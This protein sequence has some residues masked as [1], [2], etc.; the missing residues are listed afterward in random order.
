M[1]G[2]STTIPG[3]WEPMRKVGAMARELLKVAASQTW[4]T[5]VE[6]LKVSEGRV[7]HPNGQSLPFGDLVSAASLVEAPKEVAL[8]PLQE[9][10]LI[11]EPVHRVDTPAKTDGTAV[12]G[13]DV[14][15][16]GLKVATIA[17]SP[18]FGGQLEQYDASAALAIK[19]V[20]QVIPLD[21]AIAVIADTYWQAK[22]G[23][24]ALQVTFSGGDTELDNDKVYTTLQNTLDDKPLPDLRNASQQLDYE[25]FVPYLAH[26]TM[27]PMNC[28][29]KLSED[30][31]DIWVPSQSQTLTGRI[32]KEL[33]GLDESN[34]HVHLTF[35]GG[36]FGRRGEAD[37]VAQ[38]I[39]LAQR[40]GQPIK[41]IWSR[42]EDT[43]HDYYRP[44]ALT[45][46]RIGLDDNGNISE[47]H[48]QLASPS[49]FERL[50]KSF[51][52]GVV[53]WIPLT[54]IIDDPVAVEGMKHV[55]YHL[56]PE[57]D[58]RKVSL[59]VPV[60]FWRSVGHSYSGFFAESVIDEVAHQ[61]G[62]D[63]VAYRLSQMHNERA[64][65]VLERAASLANWGNRSVAQGIACH[66]SFGSFVAEVVDLS[67]D[68]NKNIT[69]HKITIVCDC[70]IV[71]N[72]DTAKAQM[73][74][75][76]MYGLVAAALGEVNIQ[77]GRVVESNFHDYPMLHLYQTPE[78]VI[79]LAPSGDAPGGVGEPGTP[80]IAA[81]LTNAI[82]AATGERIR[83]LPISQAG[84]K[85]GTAS[86][87]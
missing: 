79:E 87:T 31:C 30:R 37:F 62:V 81:A 58:Y 72:P 38:A 77:G 33:T 25:Y 48:N 23:L 86:L 69:L 70:G 45:R 26:A 27:E 18:V 24:S 54:R 1:T 40:S 44:V 59:P 61:V 36:G 47:W 9:H 53:S 20:E 16:D 4:Q 64:K 35:L 32:A 50:F 73:E 57:F 7:H 8:K 80:P 43:Q 82:Y 5:P 41:L 29:V 78:I 67:V 51:L 56:E 3:F 46:Y 10:Q 14:H 71:V 63:P 60:G 85:I 49:I 68:E 84:Y 65:R 6:S 17:Q 75:G 21:N 2:G 11:G 12:F 76:M 13:I 83:R 52:P 19:G 39:L 66:E 74:G 22:Q 42:E 28:T 55:P 15:F 34:I